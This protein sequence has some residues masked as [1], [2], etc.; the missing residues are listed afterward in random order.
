MYGPIVVVVVSDGGIVGGPRSARIADKL[1][2]ADSAGAVHI[3]LEEC[4]HGGL[5]TAG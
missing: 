3:Q 5:G 4:P 2:Q 1:E